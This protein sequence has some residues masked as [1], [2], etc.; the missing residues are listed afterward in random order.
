MHNPLNNWW[1][2]ILMYLFSILTLTFAIK[3]YRE[4]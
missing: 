1:G 2:T 4:R 3:T